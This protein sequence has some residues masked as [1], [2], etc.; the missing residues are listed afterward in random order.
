MLKSGF[1]PV[2]RLTLVYNLSF[3]L[4]FQTGVLDRSPPS[5]WRYHCIC[6]TASSCIWRMASRRRK[7]LF[8]M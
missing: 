3:K 7:D 4:K 1:K 2:L 5:V 8:H 6:C